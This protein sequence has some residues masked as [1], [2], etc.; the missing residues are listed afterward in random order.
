[1]C[2]MVTLQHC[3]Y[4]HWIYHEPAANLLLKKFGQKM[5]IIAK[6]KYT[7]TRLEWTARGQPF[8]LVITGWICVVKWPVCLKICSL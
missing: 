7:Q 2:E 1:M 6:I 5:N 4:N 3:C 8:L